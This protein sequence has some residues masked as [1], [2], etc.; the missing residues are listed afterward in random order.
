METP[1]EICACDADGIAR[2]IKPSN[3]KGISLMERIIKITVLR[4]M[5]DKVE[6]EFC[7]RR[8]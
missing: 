4:K 6:A 1:T 2:T 8:L 7:F 3:S 5:S